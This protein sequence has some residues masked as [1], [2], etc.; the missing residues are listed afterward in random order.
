MIEYP[1]Q[2]LA[3]SNDNFGSTRTKE[4]L[5]GI[6]SNLQTI[7]QVMRRFCLLVNLGAQTQRLIRSE[8]VYDT[9]SAVM[10]RLLRTSF[11]ET[12]QDETIRQGLLTFSYH[13]F[14]QWQGIKPSL[15]GFPAAYKD[16]LL[17]IELAGGAS[18]DL[19]L[20]L[21]VIGAISMFRSDEAWLL[22]LLHEYSDR[23]KIHTW[24]DMQELLKSLLWIPLLDEKE[25]SMVYNSLRLY[26]S[27]KKM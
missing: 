23:C 22:G 4:L 20:W 17:D 24:R 2:L 25:G 8:I 3:S 21:L 18:P 26:S 1:H 27:N 11:P 16:H 7:W 15:R 6:D 13:I 10:Y 14:L 9:M 5:K 19:V 12:S